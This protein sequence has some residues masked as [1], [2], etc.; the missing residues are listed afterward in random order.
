MKKL[1]L[2]TA[3]GLLALPILSQEKTGWGNERS[4]L[5]VSAGVAVPILCYGSKN[6]NNP[7]AGFAKPGFSID[8]NYS[9]RFNNT[10]GIAGTVFY[11]F[12]KAGSAAVKAVSSPGSYRLVGLLAGPV[13]SRN[14]SDRWA[15]DIKFIAGITRSMTPELQYGD[16]ILLD[17]HSVNAF[18]WSG[19]IA[20]RYNLSGNTFLQ[21]KTDHINLK[22][23]FKLQAGESGRNEQHIV[24]MNVDAGVGWKF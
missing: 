21:L 22:P 16:Q 19:G 20:L 12:N 18:T 6:V 11:A 9:Y 7:N 2:I 15:G 8:L 14:F 10:I 17:D 24:L 4:Y 3:A 1:F 23:K 13:L 5:V